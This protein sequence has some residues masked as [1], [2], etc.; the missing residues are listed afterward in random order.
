MI[1]IKKKVAT[2]IFWVQSSTIITTIVNLLTIAIFAR[3]L[4]P[5]QFGLISILIIITNFIQVFSDF[6]L[7]T[8]IIQKNGIT[9]NQLSTLFILNCLLGIFLFITTFF[10][11]SIIASFFKNP[12][13]TSLI[14]ILSCAFIFMP[15][16]QFFKALLQ[17]NL[18]F[19]KL[20]IMEVI[21]IIIYSMIAIGL[22]L[23]EL[24]VHSIVYGLLAYQISLAITGILLVSF[25]PRIWINLN[26]AS[27]LLKF[28]SWVIGEKLLNYLNR[29]L[30]Y[31]IIGR[32]LGS[33]ALGFYTLA[34]TIMLI[35]IYRIA[36]IIMQAVFPFFSQIQNDNARIR[37]AYLKILK[38]I[39][40]IIFPLMAFLFIYAS[41]II[42]TFFGSQWNPSILILKIF[43]ILGAFH[44]IGTTVGSI[45]YT[46]G[47]PDISL[48][49]NIVSIL[50]YGTAF[51]FSKKWG[52]L[53]VTIAYTTTSIFL[54]PIIQ[55]I[56]NRLINLKTRDFLLNF[57]DALKI[58]FIVIIFSILHKTCLSLSFQASA[59]IILLTGL[60]VVGLAYAFFLYLWNKSL[61]HETF[62]VLFSHD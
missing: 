34:Y 11:S 8:A 29:N 56:S 42:N 35:P 7:S 51:W 55:L 13:L 48:K 38:C 40:L 47:R 5:N 60:I 32:Y 28:G 3:L 15:V 50:L 37:T 53:G 61:V 14:Q 57:I 25:K 49:W 45:I 26:E 20:F 46:K 41:E 52:I 44:S 23:V 30:D 4:N 16:G 22:L 9:N 31:I 59:L 58:M 10:S 18:H 24:N 27:S 6:G 19:S 17:K 1:N 33:A 12:D 54:F 36:G 62:T 21:P 39:S 2:S 43:C